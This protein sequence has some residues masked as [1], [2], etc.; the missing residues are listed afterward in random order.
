MKIES[1]TTITMS[2]AEAMLLARFFG[3]CS[4]EVWR[5]IEASHRDGES[6]HALHAFGDHFWRSARS[7]TSYAPSAYSHTL[8]LCKYPSPA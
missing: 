6:V 3:G 5:A 7:E 4:D 2:A 8:T 1:D